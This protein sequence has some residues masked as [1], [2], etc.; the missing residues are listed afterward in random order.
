VDA[1]CGARGRR[2]DGGRPARRLL[3]GEHGK[4]DAGRYRQPAITQRL[5]RWCAIVERVCDRQ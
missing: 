1:V 3:E 2:R 4:L 5:C